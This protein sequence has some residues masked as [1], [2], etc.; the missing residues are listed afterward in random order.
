MRSRFAIKR[1]TTADA[2]T[3][4]TLNGPVQQLHAEGRP[5]FYKPALMNDVLVQMYRDWLAQPDHHF[6]IGEVD[7][8]PVGCIYAKIVR[9]PENPFTY[10]INALLIDQISVNPE[11]Q[12]KGYGKQLLQVAYDLARAEGIQRIM[13]DVSDFNVNAIEFYKKQGFRVHTQRMEIILD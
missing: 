6:F 8:E 2:E 10:A 4:A 12:G 1:A 7:G 5:G 3:L 13:L 11:H 9:R